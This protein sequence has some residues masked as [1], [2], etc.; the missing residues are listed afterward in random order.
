MPPRL[1][2]HD[3]DGEDLSIAELASRLGRAQ[4]TVK[5]Y[6]YD[7]IS[8]KA[9]EVKERYALASR[10]AVS[11]GRVGDVRRGGEGPDRAAS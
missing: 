4:A 9:R 5:A 10:F 7:P 11:I 2:R 6:L 1:A 8:E 3:R